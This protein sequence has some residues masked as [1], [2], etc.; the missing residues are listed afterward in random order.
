[1]VKNN[2]VASGSRVPAVWNNQN[3][4]IFCDMCIKELEAGTMEIWKELIGKETGLGWNSKLGTID[5]SDEWWHNKIEINPKYAKLRRKGISPDMEE[6]FDR[7]FMNTTATSDHAWAPSS[8]VLPTHDSSECDGILLDSGDDFDDPVYVPDET[9]QVTEKSCGKGK[10]R[11]NQQLDTQVKKEKNGNRVATKVGKLGEWNR[12]AQERFQHSGETVSR[13][14]GKLLDIVCLMAVDIIK[15]LDPEFKGVPE[16][17][18]RDSRYMPHFKDCIGAID[19]VH[20]K[21]SIPPEDQVPYIGKKGIPTQNIMAACNFDM[22]FIFACAGKYYLVDAGYP[23]MSGYLGPYKGERYHLPDFRRGT[24][25]TGSREVFNHVHS[26]LRSVIERTFGVKWSILRDIPN[27]PFDKQVKIVIATV[28]LHNYIR[29]HAQC[30]IHFDKVNDNP[31]AM[32]IEGDAQEEYH[33]TQGPGAQELETL[34]NKIA[35]SLMHASS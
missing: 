10:K 30:D 12:L 2:N 20:V 4:T 27:Y 9:I 23:Q 21:A 31:N 8:G 24:Q 3:T 18:L 13:Y 17:I 1:M 34:R 33:I 11:T 6:K 25:P 19:G 26:S 15:L 14:F 16:K 5:A 32:E 35:A 7:M 22:Q 29:R 28:A